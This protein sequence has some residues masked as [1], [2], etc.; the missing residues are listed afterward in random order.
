MAAHDAAITMGRV[1]RKGRKRATRGAAADTGPGVLPAGSR[2]PLRGPERDEPMGST[3]GNGA[4]TGL[5]TLRDLLARTP[6]TRRGTSTM[7]A[8]GLNGSNA[9][10]QEA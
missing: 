5:P 1:S 2:R 4:R 3:R 10:D 8:G 7:R 9:P 6:E